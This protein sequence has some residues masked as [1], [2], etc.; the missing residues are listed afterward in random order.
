MHNNKHPICENKYASV[1]AVPEENLGSKAIPHTFHKCK[2]DQSHNEF[3]TSGRIKQVSFFPL[4]YIWK[5]WI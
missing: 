2:C 4:L 1:G 5:T 3:G